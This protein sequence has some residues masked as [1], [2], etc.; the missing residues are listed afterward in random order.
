M[1][2]SVAEAGKET[3][4]CG[5]NV[6]GAP[7]PQQALHQSSEKLKALAMP[8]RPLQR[9]AKPPRPI[10]DAASTSSKIAN[11]PKPTDPSHSYVVRKPNPASSRADLRS[12]SP[13]HPPFRPESPRISLFSSFPSVQNPPVNKRSR[14][15]VEGSE[16]GLATEAWGMPIAKLARTDENNKFGYRDPV[17][18]SLPIEVKTEDEDELSDGIY[19]IPSPPRV[20]RVRQGRRIC[21][22]CDG[23]DLLFPPFF[24]SLSLCLYLSIS[25]P[26]FAQS[27]LT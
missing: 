7:R 20:T 15:E 13:P 16:W 11:R 23:F 18:P 17:K 8:P 26:S 9:S 27:I 1:E 22:R 19:V 6:P 2:K 21:R 5:S 10:S 24:S 12:S 25:P 4:P 3:Q 14:N